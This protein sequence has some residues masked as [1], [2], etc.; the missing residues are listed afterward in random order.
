VRVA[1]AGR[2]G[3]VALA[4]VG[5]D[6]GDSSPTAPSTKTALQAID[7]VVETNRVDH[8]AGVVHRAAERIDLQRAGDVGGD[9]LDCAADCG[10]AP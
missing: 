6:T 10:A 9:D 7:Y 2:L 4:L 8:G 5:C 3:V 1:A